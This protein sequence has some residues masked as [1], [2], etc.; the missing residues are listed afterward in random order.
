MPLASPYREARAQDATPVRQNDNGTMVSERIVCRQFVGRAAE[1]E[2]LLVR[3][4]SAVDEH[5]GMVL[6]GGEAGI[7]KSRLV[8]EYRRRLENSAIVFAAAACREFAQ[9][10]LA[11]LA[12]VLKQLEG[13]AHNP[14]A[15]PAASKDQLLDAV[16]DAFERLT[17]RRTVFIVIEDLHWADVELVH[18]LSVLAEQAAHRRLL[19]IGTY[20]NDEVGPHNPIFNPFADL[21][22]KP[23]VSL[24]Q[25]RPLSGLE[26]SELIDGCVDPTIALPAAALGDV[27]FRCG[28]NPLFA[29]ELLR[30]VVDQH[31]TGTDWTQTS[32]PVSLQG[33]IRHRLAR[34]TREDRALLSA[35]SAFGRRF[36]IDVLAETFGF[37]IDDQLAAWRRLRDL[38]LVDP[39]ADEP[40][41]Y[42]FR[43]ALTRD[44][45][46]AEMLPIER[47]RLHSQVAQ[48]VAGRPNANDYAELLA[49]SFWEAGLLAEAAPHCESAGDLARG[50]Y[51]HADAAAWYERA[52]AGF[53]GRD[54]DVARNLSKAVSAL[55]TAD[56]V[57]HAFATFTAAVAAYERLGDVAAIVT[58]SINIGSALYNGGR[59]FEAF[60]VMRKALEHVPVTDRELRHRIL[61]RMAAIR[62]A[63]R[64]IEEGWNVLAEIDE[65][66]LD[67]VSRF[68][69]EYYVAKGSLHAQRFERDA[70]LTCFKQSIE[71]FEQI[72]TDDVLG[73]DRLRYVHGSGALTALN[74]GEMALARKHRLISLEFARKIKVYEAYGLAVLAEIEHF[75][76]N[77]GAAAKLLAQIDPAR[78]FLA[79]HERALVGTL[80]GVATGDRAC[81][82]KFLDL[83]LIAEAERG[84]ATFGV[85][86]SACVC[87]QG[88]LVLGRREE[89]DTLLVRAIDALEELRAP[90]GLAPQIAALLALRPNWAERLR[91]IVGR[92][93][94]SAD[95]VN[96]ALCNLVKATITA[97][98]G[99]AVQARALA[100]AAADGFKSI[101][102]PL[103]EAQCR[104]L[105]GDERRALALYRAAGASGELRRMEQQ[106]ISRGDAPPGSVLTIRERQVAELIASGKD[107]RAVADAL[108]VSKK[109]V[110][111]YLTSIYVKLGL[112]SRAQLAA[113][114]VSADGRTT[115]QPDAV[116][117]RKER[118]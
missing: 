52:A 15:G 70:W 24:L 85:A 82:E 23:S 10:P 112:T 8:H 107:N 4:G 88:L 87:A 116:A 13:G 64:L 26:L 60:A 114:M 36:R 96:G 59:S 89:A 28:G 95:G 21:M 80:L 30:N 73:N 105:A 99:D 79:R 16:V 106:Q 5:G 1:I 19:F 69:A 91:P 57:D 27:R 63:Q 58:L 111:K 81:I 74:L 12:A 113:F 31:R 94:E 109:A 78:T 102:W 33:V 98:E 65:Q 77:L 61:I 101:G 90:F 29:E 62:A 41:A 76:G 71:L 110:E 86:Q 38:Q 43:H 7:G 55:P 75:A 2:H 103:I 97:N 118:A 83:S 84:G 35:A 72:A 93:G 51:A 104:E 50:L 49:Y 48:T 3:R 39:S 6:I 20:R 34:C 66:A 47:K 67:P 68:S 25:L 42:T 100:A 108:S 17:E 18:I 54:A 45:I 53:A 115:Q 40:L 9:R 32:V 56:A 46:Y 92:F 117:L 44:V 14:F 37:P 22:R 11:P